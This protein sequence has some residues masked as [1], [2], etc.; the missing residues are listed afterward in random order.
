MTHE[1]G[2]T[3][4]TVFVHDRGQVVLELTDQVG[5]PTDNLTRADLA[6]RYLWGPAVDQLLAE[7]QVH[8]DG[9]DMVTDGTLLALIDQLGTVRDLVDNDADVRLHLAFDSFGNITDEAHYNAAGA[10]TNS[11]VC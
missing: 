7:E 3:T 2:H 10:T 9:R 6:K 11:V 8:W 4:R 5:G 1:D